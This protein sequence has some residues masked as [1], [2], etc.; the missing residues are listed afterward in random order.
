MPRSFKHIDK[1]GVELEGGWW[2]GYQRLEPSWG[3]NPPNSPTKAW[4]LDWHGDGSVNVATTHINSE[5]D[6]THPHYGTG[7]YQGEGV[8]NPPQDPNNI[9]RWMKYNYPLWVNESCGMH[10]HMSFK[11]IIDYERIMEEEFVKHFE[12]SMEAWGKDN[13]INYDPFWNRL[14]GLNRYCQRNGASSAQAMINHKLLKKEGRDESYTKYYHLNF[15]AWKKYKTVEC[16][17]LPMFPTAQQGADA[18][19]DLLWLFEKYLRQPYKSEYQPKTVR[20]SEEMRQQL[21]GVAAENKERVLK[22]ENGE[23]GTHYSIQESANLISDVVVRT[24]QD[25]N[26]RSAQL[27]EFPVRAD[28]PPRYSL[29]YTRTN[30]GNLEETVRNAENRLRQMPT[31][32]TLPP[33]APLP[34][35]V[36]DVVEEDD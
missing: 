34:D 31:T 3:K 8:C 5:K 27:P 22:I 32:W 33:D 6:T 20:I 4:L 16:R 15:G 11:N 26:M 2:Q 28:E 23:K 13:K 10:V 1:V 9:H 12:E 29:R 24:T 36:E 35:V 21:E 7:L 17:L 30:W 18:V 25:P 14:R 19:Y